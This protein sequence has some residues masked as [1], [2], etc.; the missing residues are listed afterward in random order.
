MTQSIEFV[1]RQTYHPGP[2]PLALA[3]VH[4]VLFL[5]SVAATAALTRGGHIP[6]PFDGASGTL[7]FSD[8]APAIGVSSFL[9]LGAAIVLGLFSATVTSRLTFY[10]VRA[11]G[12]SIAFYGGIT[13]ALLSA[14][15]ALIAWS[16]AATD[17]VALISSGRALH[18]LM[19]A[20]GGIGHV[21]ML[22]LLLAGVSVSAGITHLLPRW[23]IALG[24]ALAAT[25]ELATFT[26]AVPVAVY[27][28]PVGRFLSFVWLIGAG[29]ALENG[30]LSNRIR[31][32]PENRF[33]ELHP[34]R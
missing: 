20:L 33:D 1:P 21:A 27:L 25:S 24:L 16:L 10:G 32:R 12:V 28:I 7:F 15:S 9:Q 26:L 31:E 6:S 34:A 22:G 13:A 5:G 30:R 29:A 18:F 2:S 8:H 3:V 11:A 17:A 23:L 14:L 19:F 4:T